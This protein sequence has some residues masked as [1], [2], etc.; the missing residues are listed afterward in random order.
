MSLIAPRAFAVEAGV[1]EGASPIEYSHDEF[2]RAKVPYDR[3]GLSDRIEFI[4]HAEGHVSAT[5]RA[6]EFLDQHLERSHE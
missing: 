3:L 5:R 6:F 4:A 2:G 1:Q